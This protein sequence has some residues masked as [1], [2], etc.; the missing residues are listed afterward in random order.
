VSSSSSTIARHHKQLP[1]LLLRRRRIAQQSYDSR[2][3]FVSESNS[4]SSSSNEVASSG[5]AT[6]TTAKSRSLIVSTRLNHRQ[7]L[8]VTTDGPVMSSVQ[9]G[10]AVAFL[11]TSGTLL[12]GVVGVGR[13]NTPSID[14][15]MPAGVVPT[16]GY[17]YATLFFVHDE[18]LLKESFTAEIE[19]RLRTNAAQLVSGVD[20]EDVARRLRTRRRRL[21]AYYISD[22]AQVLIDM[23]GTTSYRVV[24]HV[25]GALLLVGEQQYV[26]PTAT[27]LPVRLDGQMFTFASSSY[28]KLYHAGT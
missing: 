4:S 23:H 9:P 21:S 3:T 22:L 13:D 20:L 11:D 8:I 6:S 25:V 2:R 19:Q 28:R 18:Q 7:A 17:R 5:S 10:D 15:T 26:A 14:V 12:F 1:L 27:W 16:E 24:D